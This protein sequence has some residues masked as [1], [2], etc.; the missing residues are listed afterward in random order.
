LA[1]DGHCE[2]QIPCPANCN[3]CADS[4]TCTACNS[5]FYLDPASNTCVSCP[6]TCSSCTDATTCGACSEGYT[7]SN[8]TCVLLCPPLCVT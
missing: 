1:S 2:P 8:N 5:A 4:A 6:E 3:S 7:L